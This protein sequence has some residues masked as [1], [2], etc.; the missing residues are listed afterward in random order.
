VIP[1]KR[2]S[3]EEL[4]R[5]V[6]AR[7]W[8]V[9][10]AGVVGAILAFGVARVL[11]VK[12]ESA[13]TIMLVPQ[14]V[15]EG[16][17][18]P[19]VTFRFEDQLNTISPE[20]LSRVRLERVINE[21]DLYRNL[22]APRTMDDIVQLMRS[23]IT[24]KL[25]AG[26]SFRVSYVSNDPQV[27]MKVATRLAS[28]FI[29][30]N[31]KD[32]K[33]VADNTSQFIDEELENAKKSLVEQEKRLANYKTANGGELPTQLA[34]NQQMLQGD[35]LQLQGLLE[36]ISHDRDRRLA[37]DQQLASLATDLDGSGTKS[38]GSATTPHGSPVADQ[39]DKERATLQDLSSRGY[40]EAHP[41]VIRAKQVVRD[42]E[43]QL[44]REVT[45]RRA[46]PT[47]EPAMPNPIAVARQDRAIALR[48]D[49]QMIDR[50]IATKQAD[51]RRLRE[52]IDQLR[53]HI[54]AT[55]TRESELTSLT[56]DYDTVSKLYT[57][58]LGK[59]KDSEIARNLENRQIGAQ[60]K[61][62]DP[63]SVPTRPISPN[64]PKL[65]MAG[66]ALGLALA[67]GLI[68]FVEYRNSGLR[69]EDEVA[70]CLGLP[71]IAVVPMMTMP[72]TRQTPRL[73]RLLGP[74]SETKTL[75]ASSGQ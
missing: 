12:F 52:S 22:R 37:L 20:I 25:V 75:T 19:T 13:T 14:R 61:L 8:L 15:P 35:Q 50:Q 59:K 29:E 64:R 70:A 53:R 32:R 62:L 41:D 51:E 28:L 34:A 67:L 38:A 36:S 73:K 54:D 47:A 43:Q 11:P 74:L 31:I 48:A 24:V 1:G 23:D 10:V 30:E 66:G 58:L 71:V 46:E 18:N 4:V 26:D 49:L 69:T 72:A 6:W 3:P 16:Y 60:F 21:F 42:L 27:A 45:R 5:I 17:F 39:L 56:R 57:T 44:A 65:T 63:A 40:T 9:V 55:P 68:A 7:K 33:V 2:Y